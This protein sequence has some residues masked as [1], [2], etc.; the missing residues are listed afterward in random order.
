MSIDN[1]II[2]TPIVPLELLGIDEEETTLRFSM[3]E[4]KDE[5]GRIFLP[6]VLVRAGIFK[7]TTEIKRISKQRMDSKKLK[8]PLQKNLW[9]NLEAPEFTP[10]KI[11]KNVFWLIVGE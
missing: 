3:E 9:R 4:L 7:S 1:I 6:R 11:G 8:D 2:G 5:N 10:F